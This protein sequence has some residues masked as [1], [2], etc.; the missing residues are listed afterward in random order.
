MCVLRKKRKLVLGCTNVSVCISL[1]TLLQV[2]RSKCLLTL[3]I[4]LIK[5]FA[6]TYQLYFLMLN[7]LHFVSGLNIPFGIFTEKISVEH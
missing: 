7:A 1:E 2:L 5:Y 4:N 6:I 3:N